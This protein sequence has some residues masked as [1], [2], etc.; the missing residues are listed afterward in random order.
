MLNK[1]IN[2]IGFILANI[3]SGSALKLWPPLIHE[4][5]KAGVE[6]F[7]FPGGRLN[8]SD[9]EERIKN[10]L[11]K[12]VDSH[13]DGI[14]SWASSLGGFVKIGEL[15][16]FHNQFKRIPL[17]TM[18]HSMPG[19]PN[20]EIDAYNGMFPLLEHLYSVH[21]YRKIAYLQGP[22]EHKSAQD[23]Y[24]AY[25]HFL[26]QKK[27]RFDARLVSSPFAWNEG[28]QA[29]KEL[30]I[31][32][33]LIPGKDFDVL[34]AASD[35]QLYD[36][37][38]VLIERGIKIPQDLGIAGFN[39]S[40]E[41]R[42]AIPSF[43]TVHL[44]F[45]EQA[46]AAFKDLLKAIEGYPVQNEKI[47][48][49]QLIIRN[50]CGCNELNKVRKYMPEGNRV[51]NLELDEGD[52]NLEQIRTIVIEE[53]NAY[54]CTKWSASFADS[55]IAS[56][57]QDEDIFFTTFSNI[58]DDQLQTNNNLTLWQ[59][60]ISAVIS[61]III[62]LPDQ[63]RDTAILMLDQARIIVADAIIRT[64]QMQQ[65]ISEKQW[66]IIRELEINLINIQSRY[67]VS[68]T[69]AK[70]MPMLN[71]SAAYIIEE[72][73]DGKKALIAGFD[74][75]EVFQFNTPLIC[76]DDE[77]VPRSAFK[78]KPGTIWIVEPL[79]GKKSFLGWMVIN[80]GYPIGTMYEE[81]RSAVSNCLLNLR[82]IDTLKK[83]QKEAE[84]AE[85][86]KTKFLETIGGEF[87]VPL[88]QIGEISNQIL[89][90]REYFLRDDVFS[91][92]MTIKSLAEKQLILTEN[93]IELAKSETGDLV[94][95]LYIVPFVAILQ[96]LQ[97]NEKIK[98]MIIPEYDL[99]LI[100]VDIE[101]IKKVF[102]L[103]LND[104]GLRDV[105]YKIHP[106]YLSCQYEVSQKLEELENLKSS[107]QLAQR[108]IAAHGGMLEYEHIDQI[109]VRWTIKLPLPTLYGSMSSIQINKGE[110]VMISDDQDAKKTHPL[111]AELTVTKESITSLLTNYNRLKN[112]SLIFLNGSEYSIKKLAS[113][114]NLFS[115]PAI[116]KI[117]FAVLE[118]KIEIIKYRTLLD[119]FGFTLSKNDTLVILSKD[120]R[121][122][123]T[124]IEMF[125]ETMSIDVLALHD[126]EE[127]GE[128]LQ[129]GVKIKI[130]ITSFIDIQMINNIYNVFGYNY[131]PVIMVLA[132][133]ILGEKDINIVKDENNIILLNN[134]VLNYD[135]ML[136]IIH[137][138]LQSNRTTNTF[139]N[140]IVKKAI[141]YLNQNFAN[142]IMRWKLAE[143]VNVSEDYLTRVF[144]KE[145]N[146]S[147]WDYLIRFRIN[148]SKQLLIN[149]ADSISQIA[150]KSG[151]S[152]QA[153]FCRVFHKLI[154]MSPLIYRKNYNKSWSE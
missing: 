14:L 120:L 94:L 41:S 143:Y 36:A 145:L 88:K 91:A 35:M 30:I 61:K 58:I 108:L 144:K 38:Q 129:S 92:I 66:L 67:E 59:D 50:S 73:Y 68:T 16:E 100:Y 87:L 121:F 81:I 106:N 118:N 72:Q 47:L 95:D 150:E 102:E 114:H 104:N 112:I 9:P 70:W 78:S 133:H 32:R 55:F 138:I 18:A 107:I 136:K 76:Q 69:I 65:W 40:I 148:Q 34:V 98:R 6:F 132:N 149:T 53:I 103:I 122:K 5:K 12:Y 64:H 57:K 140:V 26:N 22:V 137:D 117:S 127:I 23:R 89:S 49:G 124:L 119:Y 109:A 51:R 134:G 8:A 31:E 93:I 128:C 142:N 42:I 52:A 62:L 154:G 116:K 37:L 39:D 123:E 29:I 20:V 105:A 24:R 19:F 28:K 63:L 113:L 151:F 33:T 2:R 82:A 141:Y 86:I 101:K 111:F 153:Y 48:E 13:I 83:A 60:I 85:K 71:I 74:E 126:F 139:S 110:V 1:R 146:I 79:C 46:I 7:I 84:T 45:E 147:P 43:T 54:Y 96:T 75:E 130:I 131:K 115:I 80:L 97:I 11:Y 135:E 99:P 10:T 125:S 90:H 15:T 21:G 44:P 25:K 4:V 77:L 17:V 27:I 3:H 152:D 56:L